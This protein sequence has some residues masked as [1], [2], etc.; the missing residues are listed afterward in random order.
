VKQA[1]YV[2]KVA[3]RRT[4]QSVLL[5]AIALRAQ[6]RP[7]N[8][9]QEPILQAMVPPVKRTASLVPLVLPVSLRVL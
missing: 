1:I 4:L 6:L 8:A 9:L 7:S 2:R 3:A 5:V